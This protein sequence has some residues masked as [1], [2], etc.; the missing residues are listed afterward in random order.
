[1][2][3]HLPEH[4]L[5]VDEFET[6]FK[7]A[8]EHDR[9]AAEKMAQVAAEAAVNAT[10]TPVTPGA[11]GDDDE[12]ADETDSE[13]DGDEAT[14]ALPSNASNGEAPD[15]PK[16]GDGNVPEQATNADEST[17]DKVAADESSSGVSE[18]LGPTVEAAESSVTGEIL[19][20]NYLA[21]TPLI[22]FSCW[23]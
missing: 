3:N 11:P 9:E 2:R 15:L 21:L 1:M 22:K 5:T 23:R 7:Q 20:L 13:L 4:G 14:T 19:L 12:A 8:E 6:Y 17:A 10:S 18:P 16:E